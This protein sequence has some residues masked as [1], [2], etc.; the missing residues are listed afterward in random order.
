[1]ES[2]RQS[3]NWLNGHPLHQWFGVGTTSTGYVETLKLEN[4]LLHGKQ[5]H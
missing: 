5:A 1:G 4:N 2:W 3:D